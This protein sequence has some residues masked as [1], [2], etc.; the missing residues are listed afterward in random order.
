MKAYDLLDY[1]RVLN[2][3]YYNLHKFNKISKVNNFPH[4]PEKFH[5][6]ANQAPPNV[7]AYGTLR[8]YIWCILSV[9]TSTETNILQPKTSNSMALFIRKAVLL[10]V[11]FLF[12][13][14]LCD[15]RKRRYI[16]VKNELKANGDLSLTVH[17]KS[18]NH[19]IGVK[20]LAP[21]GSFEFS[22]KPNIWGTTLY[23]C[24]FSWRGQLKWFD[25]YRD[26]RDKNLDSKVQW[27]ILP[28]GACRT[29]WDEESFSECIEWNKD[30]WT[31][32]IYV[33]VSLFIFNK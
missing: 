15:A 29:T 30:N 11:L 27:S 19:D 3:S 4:I 2:T 33:R 24:S 25:V 12:T 28:E 10:T 31:H 6:P 16:R 21:H 26:K 7:I 32:I 20:V 8:V 17:C 9:S 23:Y 13:L 18:K 5:Y 1:A 22:F 14:T